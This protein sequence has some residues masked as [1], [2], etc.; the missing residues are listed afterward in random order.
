MIQTNR[1]GQWSGL[2]RQ[3]LAWLLMVEGIGQT[4]LRLIIMAHRKGEVDL[5][6]LWRQ[7]AKLAKLLKLEKIEESVIKLQSEYTPT[8]VG[9]WLSQQQIQIITEEDIVFPPLLKQIHEPPMMLFFQGVLDESWWGL[10][11]AVVGSRHMTEYGR[12]ATNSLVAELVDLGATIISGGM[13]GVD[14]EAHQTAIKHQGKTVILLGHGFGHVYPD[15]IQPKHQAILEGG[16]VIMS[17][18]APLTAPSK[19]SFVAR[20][21]LV[22]GMSQTVLVVEAAIKSGTH[23]TVEFALEEGRDVCA[24]PGPISNPYSQGTKWLINQGARLVTLGAE[25]IS[26]ETSFDFP[27]LTNNSSTPVNRMRHGLINPEGRS[28]G[29]SDNDIKPKS[30]GPPNP[31][32]QKKKEPSLQTKLLDLLEAQPLSVDQI[33]Q[34]LGETTGSQPPVGLSQVLT[35]LTQLEMMGQVARFGQYYRSG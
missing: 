23:L 3:A 32:Q 11:V 21:R 6:N 13:Y 31:H 1:V 25:V 30:L 24:V 9:E 34:L 27:G 29:H 10:P 18:F 28:L 15:W 8:K 22:A 5:V 19:G 20:N 35:E 26:P 12:M 33:L 16:G 2:E 7:P 17:Q 14:L 4:R